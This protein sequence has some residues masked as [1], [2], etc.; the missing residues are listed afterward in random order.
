MFIVISI[1]IYQINLFSQISLSHVLWCHIE[2]YRLKSRIVEY[3]IQRSIILQPTCLCRITICSSFRSTESNT[4]HIIQTKRLTFRHRTIVRITSTVLASWSRNVY[5][6]CVPSIKPISRIVRVYCYCTALTLT[7]IRCIVRPVAPQVPADNSS[8]CKNITNLNRWR[9]WSNQKS[10]SV[11]FWKDVLVLLLTSTEYSRSE[12][13]HW[14]CGSDYHSNG[15]ISCIRC[16][17][18]SCRCCHC[19]S[20]YA[21]CYLG[22]I[23]SIGCSFHSCRCC[24]SCLDCVC[25]YF[26]WNILQILFAKKVMV[27]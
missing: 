27:S 13:R 10:N 21:C 23:S 16:S 1:R 9:Y 8:A 7:E 4:G 3:L 25:H 22:W 26:G 18:H 12:Y 2:Y 19:R 20:D 15:R 17:F 6:A 11:M 14:T 24:H 5:I